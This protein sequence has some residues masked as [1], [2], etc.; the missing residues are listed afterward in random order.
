MR[1][2][3]ADDLRKVLLRIVKLLDE[4]LVALRF[5]ERVE[6]DALHVLDDRELERFLVVNLA[7]DHR[8]FVE[9]GALRRAP[10]TLAG[11]DLE[12][13]RIFARTDEQGLH[14]AFFADR[15]RQLFE[16]RRIEFSPRV[17]AV[18]DDRTDR[19]P[20]L[21]R[22]IVVF[23]RTRTLHR[24]HVAD[25]CGEAAAEPRGFF[26]HGRLPHAANNCRSRRMTSVA[27][28]KYAWL[29]AHLRS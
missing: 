17:G 9:S 20:P 15:V 4:L 29:P 3:L 10:A 12:N 24:G 28:F 22:R 7:D 25:Q 14:H 26:C 5:L 19:K 18:G 21:A 1:A 13:R 27:S 16:L 23:G 6:I 2:R 8:H 11:N